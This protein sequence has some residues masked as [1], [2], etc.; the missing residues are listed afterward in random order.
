[1][2]TCP[3][4]IIEY[5]HEYL[6]GDISREHEQV[7]K[8]HLKTCTAC[9]KHMHQLSDAVA[10]IKSAAQITAPPHFEEKVMKRLPR[11][12]NRLGI[13]NWLRRHPF[14]VAAAMF[15]LFMSA[16]LFGSFNDDKFSVTKQPNLVVEGQTVIVPEGEVVKG[17]IV[18]KNGDIVVEGEVDGNVIVINGE[19]MASTAV[20]TGQIHEIDQVFEWVWYEVKRMTK[21]FLALFENGK[22]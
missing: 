21:D 12:K 3:Q 4:H 18:V 16:T 22:D 7:L 15:I 19:Y 9:Q 13:Q 6:D 1:M 17:D 14:L 20:V 11:P 2:S 10:F 8:Q 5:M